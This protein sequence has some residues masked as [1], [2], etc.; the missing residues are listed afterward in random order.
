M[1]DLPGQVL[2]VAEKVFVEPEVEYDSIGSEYFESEQAVFFV[3][4]EKPVI[5]E[6]VEYE[7]EFVEFVEDLYYLDLVDLVVDKG[8]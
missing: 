8:L 4:E 7:A 3:P 5:V 2:W 6:V 1:V